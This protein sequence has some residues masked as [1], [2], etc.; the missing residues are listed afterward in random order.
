M[1]WMMVRSLGK[2]LTL[3]L[4]PPP[5]N[6][7]KEEET[8]ETRREGDWG[9]CRLG[10]TCWRWRHSRMGGLGGGTADEVIL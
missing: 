7:G 10:G 5:P 6:V 8:F 2:P 1:Q 3:S 4:N 9:A